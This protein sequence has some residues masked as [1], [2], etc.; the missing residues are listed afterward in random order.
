[1]ESDFALEKE[2]EKFID[3]CEGLYARLASGPLSTHDRDAVIIIAHD[4]LT[5]L[6]G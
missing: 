1:M 2:T 3:A 5:E 4:L 6:H